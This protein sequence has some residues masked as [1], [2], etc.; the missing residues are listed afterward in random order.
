MEVNI[1]SHVENWTP[2]YRKLV[3]RANFVYERA[4]PLNPDGVP[5]RKDGVPSADGL[6]MGNGR[7]GGIVRGTPEGIYCQINRPDVLGNNSY[8][9]L[10]TGQMLVNGCGQMLVDLGETPFSGQDM[11]QSLNHYDALGSFEGGGVVIRALFHHELDVLALEVTDNRAKP[12][13]VR[14][15][16]RMLREPKREIGPRP[17]T[18]ISA[19]RQ[20]GEAATLTQT[21]HEAAEPEF[22]ESE[23][24]CRS[25][26]TAQFAGRKGTTRLIDERNVALEAAAGKGTFLILVGS[27]ATLDKEFDVVAHALEQGRTAADKGFNDLFAENQIWWHNFWGQ[28][29]IEARSDNG[30]AEFLARGWTAWLYQMACTSRGT[31]APHWNTGLWYPYGDWIMD[32]N[33]PRYWGANLSPYYRA[34]PMANHLEL[35]QPYFD[36]YFRAYD[37]GRWHAEH[38]RGAKDGIFLSETHYWNGSRRY[39]ERVAEEFRRY[40]LEELK[41]EDFSETARQ[42]AEAACR[43]GSDEGNA[44][45]PKAP[46]PYWYHTHCFSTGAKVAWRFWL[47]YEYTLD[48]NWLSQRA[49]PLLRG[50]AEFYRNYPNVRKEADGKYH[51]NNVHSHEPVWGGQDT[52]E[53]L[54]AMRAMTA[55]A[56]RASEILGVDKDL[57]PLWRDIYENATPIPTTKEQNVVA[58]PHDET[59]PEGW[60]QGR[61]PVVVSSQELESGVPVRQAVDYDLLTLETENPD[62]WRLSAGSLE[63]NCWYHDLLAGRATFCLSEIPATVVMMGR[64]EQAKAFLPQQLRGVGWRDEVKILTN[65]LMANVWM[66]RESITN[67][68]Y[69][70]N[71]D[72]VQHALMQSVASEPGSEPVIRVFPAWPRE[73]DVRFKL[74]ARRGF[75]V[76]ASQQKGVIKFVHIESKL[77]GTC[78]LRNPWPD[79][80]V[81]IHRD[82]KAAEQLAGNILEF[83]TR[84]SERLCLNRACPGDLTIRLQ[85]SRVIKGVEQKRERKKKQ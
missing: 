37:N 32:W 45:Q 8:T 76:T 9:G 63:L 53:E 14:V 50:M 43:A 21:Y 44:C 4:L 6:P 80:P 36:L 5:V 83:D 41:F 77:G 13:P 3:S 35:V 78:R 33:G 64:A 85:N 27:A 38:L 26:L 39:P 67:E 17:W 46:R 28:S 30:D 57:R 73:W 12:R 84:K 72:N 82:G 23:H 51:I 60:A 18:A 71:A 24:Y 74:A 66:G 68:G 11:R 52:M 55:L 79:A 56:A 19:L 49:Y 2:D 25:A 47:A 29:F 20:E 61:Q 48:R 1:E 15:T 16:L 54:C 42:Y 70:W 75:L 65:N 58:L 10:K 81:T 59:S 7:M 34:L 62:T 22:P 69:G 31:I 40:L